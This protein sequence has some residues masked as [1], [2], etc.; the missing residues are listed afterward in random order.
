M[1]LGMYLTRRK[2]V[3]AKWEHRNVNGKIEIKIGDKELPVDF[4]KVSYIIEDVGYWRKANE[5]HKWFV[6]NVQ[7]GVDDCKEYYVELD[8][9]QELLNLCKEVYKEPT[10]AKELLPVQ[11]SYEYNEWYF[12][13]IKSTIDMLEE[14][15]QEEMKSRDNGIYNEIYYQASW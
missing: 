2:Y 11:G 7:N 12:Q 1:G 9:L 4:K 13:D 15:I 3:G 6:D 5:I 14:L 10:R 8:K